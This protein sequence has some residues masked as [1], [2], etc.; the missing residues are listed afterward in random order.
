MLGGLQPRQ[1]LTQLLNFALVLS[2]AFMLWKG[3]SVATDSPSPIVV[4]LSGSMEPAFQRGDLLFLWNRGQDTQVGEI[5][6]YNVKGKDIPIVHRVVRRYGG[7]DEPLQ[8]L[9]KGDNNLADDTELYARGQD[10]LTRSTDIIGSVIGYVP[11]V[12][13]VTIL[14]S[15]HPWLKTVLLGLMGVMVVLQ[16]E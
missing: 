14:L 12:G 5:V 4:V 6:V 9:T 11:F 8:L 1:L 16:R 10:Y 2:T 7:G 3:L 13:Y 15:E